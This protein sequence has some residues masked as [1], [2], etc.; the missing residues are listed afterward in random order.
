MPDHTPDWRRIARTYVNSH[1]VDDDA[2]DEIVE[3]AEELYRSM[4]ATGLAPEAARAAV[5]AEMVDLPPLMRAARAARRRRLAPAPE[6]PARG[7]FRWAVAFGRDIGHGVRLLIARPAFTAVAV[8]TLALGIG[9][10]TAIFS[11]VHTI[12]LAPLPFEHPDRLVRV[13]ETDADNPQNVFIVSAPNFKDWQA[14]ATAFERMAIW[15]NRQ[16]N[17]SG[18]DEPAQAYGMRVSASVFPML[19][20]RPQLGRTFTDA[21]DAPGHDVVVLGDTIWRTRFGGRPD[22]VGKTIRVNGRPHEVIGVMPPSFIFAQRRQQVFVPIAFNAEADAHRDSHSFLVAAR[23]KPGV[24]FDAAK[25]EMQSLGLRLAKEHQENEGESATIT[26]LTDVGSASLSQTFSALSGAVAL[27]LLIACVNVANLLLAQ[28]SVRHREFSIRAALGASRRRLASQLFAEGLLLS[29]VGAAAGVGVAWGAIRIMQDTLP[30]T[31]ANAPFRSAVGA[32][33]ATEVLLFTIAVAF[34][35]AVLFSLAPMLGLSRDNTGTALKAGGGRG[36]TSVHSRA[37][38]VLIAAE[39]ALAVMIL[40]GA[41]LLIKSM[42]RLLAV[43]PGL[44]VER[45][46]VTPLAL[47]QKDL[48]G[49][50]E[51]TTFCTDLDQAVRAVP[52]VTAAGAVSHLPLSG[53]N[54][55]RGL[56]LEGKTTPPE[57]YSASYRLTCPGYFATLGIQMVR[58]RD[59]TPADTTTAPRVAIINEEMAARYWPGEDPVG[60]RLMIGS[61]AEEARWMT[62]VGVARTVRHLG[63]DGPASRELFLPYSQSAWPVMTVVIKTATRDAPIPELRRALRNLDP[64]RPVAAWRT[65]EDIVVESTGPRRFPM[66]LLAS[67]AVVALALAVIG[68]FGVVSYLVTQRTREIGIR[69]ALGARAGQLVGMVVR[70]ALTPIGVGLA[71]GI[72]GALASARFVSSFLFEV[73]PYD[74]AVL[75]AVA[76]LLAVAGLAASALPARRAAAV[77]PLVVLKEE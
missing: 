60:R 14:Q 69:M 32:P 68:V 56:T 24:T 27:L 50:P 66:L 57:G 7:R 17:V 37:R 71:V 51:R 19:G 55:G 4:C 5:E 49:P 64:E 29:I 53:A 31:V 38:S 11:L 16:F 39:V 61:A 76:L 44:D 58:G 35:T 26:P 22:I 62:V 59:F 65:M 25:A 52:G 46:V 63:L 54:A 42:A 10:N 73:K 3:H 18:G 12:I 34:V 72:A 6:A 2:F 41:G 21:E 15:E 43:D 75:A 48:Y 74:P 30:F 20:V 23:L 40:A 13:W 1:D 28:A 36:G 9:A 47:P 8:A 67:F 70:R 45:V 33:L 77:D